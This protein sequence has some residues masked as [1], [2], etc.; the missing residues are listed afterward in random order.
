MMGSKSIRELEAIKESGDVLGRITDMR[1][2]GSRIFCYP[3][4]L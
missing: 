4:F 2:D 1:K 3:F